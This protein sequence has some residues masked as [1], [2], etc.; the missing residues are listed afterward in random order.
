MKWM[1]ETVGDISVPLGTALATTTTRSLPVLR[2]R[3]VTH[4]MEAVDRVSSQTVLKSWHKTGLSRALFDDKPM[5]PVLFD[6][7][8]HNKE[9]A[10]DDGPLV[11]DA[12][13]HEP[14]DFEPQEFVAQFVSVGRKAVNYTVDPECSRAEESPHLIEARMR[15]EKKR[16]KPKRGRPTL[17]SKKILPGQK[18]LKI[19]SLSRKRA[20]ED[21][22]AID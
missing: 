21:L 5:C 17:L 8:V 4:L 3:K 9:L 14:D 18:T 15:R 22:E 1:S 2:T 7:I 20:R 12:D 13:S 10:V 19:E 16:M 11:D 6:I